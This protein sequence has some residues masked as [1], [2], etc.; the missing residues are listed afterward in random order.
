MTPGQQLD[1]LKASPT[2]PA[3]PRWTLALAV[4]SFAMAA[5]GAAYQQWLWAGLAGATALLAVKVSL[6]G[7]HRRNAIAAARGGARAMAR[8]GMAA[9][10]R[11]GVR[12]WRAVVLVDMLSEWSFEF[13]PDHW[14]PAEGTFMAE[15][16]FA[17]QIAWPALVLT[18]HG[19][20]Y[21]SSHPQRRIPR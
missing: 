17:P 9:A 19:L 21:P 6:G 15:I 8:V 5:G 11:G 18:E 2:W 12:V 16:C 7:P 4:L 3:H 1:A 14:A 10:D 20:L 13:V